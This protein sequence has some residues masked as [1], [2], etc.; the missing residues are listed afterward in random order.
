MKL[1]KSKFTNSNN[2]FYNPLFK[3]YAILVK[4]Y[5]KSVHIKTHF[6]VSRGA[7]GGKVITYRNLCCLLM[8][9]ILPMLRQTQINETKSE[10]AHIR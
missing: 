4:Q 8:A 9:E 3:T 5:K 2:S 7:K 1:F 6:L 10:Q